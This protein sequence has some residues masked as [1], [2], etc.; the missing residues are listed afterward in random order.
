MNKKF[1]IF[2]AATPPHSQK[3]KF[4]PFKTLTTRFSNI[5]A[6]SR[7][8]VEN[9]ANKA[10]NWAQY[11]LSKAVLHLEKEGRVLLAY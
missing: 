11:Y 9:G 4:H 1:F 3:T 5:E 6:L 10:F 7:F 8:Q 2:G